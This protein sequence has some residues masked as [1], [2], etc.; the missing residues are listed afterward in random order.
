MAERFDEVR[1]WAA[2]YQIPESRSPF[3][4]EWMEREY[5]RLGRN[6]LPVAIVFEDIDSLARFLGAG[7]RRE[8][9]E[10]RTAVTYLRDTLPELL[11][12]ARRRPFVLLKL[13]REVPRLIAVTQWI[14]ANPRPD[15]YLRQLP[16]AGVDTKFV[17]RHRKLLADWLNLVLP[18][19]NIEDS[20]RGVRSFEQRYGFKSRPEHVRFRILDPALKVS[21][22]S[23][24]SVPAAEFARWSAPGV[25]RVF[26]LENDVTGLA[27]PNCP[28][29]IV[30]FGRGFFSALLGEAQW[31]LEVEVVYWGDIDTHGFAILDRFRVHVPHTQSMLMDRDTLL[32]HEAQWGVEPAPTDTPLTH[33]TKA[34]AELYDELRY[35]RIRPRV[36]LEQ[37]LVAFTAI[38]RAVAE[39]SGE[40]S[41]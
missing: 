14:R 37:E 26:V 2:G 24:L 40:P 31:L 9:A 20:F 38:Q 25:R 16:V 23:D 32:E 19:S 12:W 17:E 5:R 27:F 3:T 36:R 41:P 18:E 28:S 35:D 4:V 11:A 30:L 33:L 29:S 1:T 13:A 34:E 39:L 6:R 10:Y 8:L 21:G 15:I 7:P 22:F